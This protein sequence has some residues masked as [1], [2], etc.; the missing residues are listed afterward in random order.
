MSV[1]VRIHPLLQEFTGGQEVAEVSGRNV[2]ECLDHLEIQFPGIKRGL[3]DKRGK[4][5][6]YL[7]IYINS[8]SSYPEELT[9]SVNDGDELTIVILVGGG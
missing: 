3:C 9:K 5:L 4:V 7:E 8:E 1:K 6:N 2:G